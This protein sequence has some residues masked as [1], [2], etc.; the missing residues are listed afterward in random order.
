MKKGNTWS[1]DKTKVS[2]ITTQK[3]KLKCKITGHTLQNRKAIYGIK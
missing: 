1:R 2:D 3:A